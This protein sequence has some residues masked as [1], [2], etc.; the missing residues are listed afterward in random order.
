MDKQTKDAIVQNV[1]YV[2]G[3]ILLAVVTKKVM[4][5]DFGRTLKM[6]GA[7]VVKKTADAQVKHWEHVAASAATAYQ[8]ARI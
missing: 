1:V 8:K 4:Q 5:P 3:M 2:A 6:R 7:L